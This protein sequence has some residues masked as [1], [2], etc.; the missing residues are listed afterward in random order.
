MKQ[1]VEPFRSQWAAFRAAAQQHDHIT[2]I[3]HINPDPDAIASAVGAC[4]LLAACGVSAEILYE[5]N[6]GRAVNKAFVEYLGRPLQPL[7]AVPRSPILLVDTQPTNGNAPRGTETAVWGIFDHHPL[8]KATATA[9][10]A[11][12]RI[13]GSTAT[14]IAHYLYAAEVEPSEQLATALFFGIKTDT[15]DL[16]RMVTPLDL[17][18]YDWL[19]GLS[20]RVG[21]KKIE[22]AQVSADYFQHTHATLKAARLH[23]RLLFAYIGFIPYPDMAAEMADW[24]MRFDGSDWILCIGVYAHKLVLSLRAH[25]PDV[26]AGE[27]MQHIVAELGTGGGHSTMAGGQVAL[28]NFDDPI[29]L[30]KQFRNRALAY[31]GIPQQ[32]GQKLLQVKT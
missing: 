10:F 22:N 7:F 5:G 11:D 14:L 16:E 30:A 12:V 1:F 32:K 17:H 15:L 6:I 31:L 2:V 9:K 27:L 26:G 18:A 25:P 21:L 8:R 13:A 23:D 28:D 29:A 3:P 4:A 20:D 24:L 19:R